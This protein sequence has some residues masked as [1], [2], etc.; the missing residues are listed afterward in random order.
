MSLPYIIYYYISPSG[1]N[2]VSQFLDSLNKKQ[3]SKV[4]RIFQYIKVYGLSAILPHTKKLS[5][6]PLWEIRILGEDNIRI[7]YVILIQ[8]TVLI[9]HGFIKKSQ[10]TPPKEIQI[11]LS[12]LKQWKKQRPFDK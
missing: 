6:T 2:P 4:L 8:N 7:F 5:G 10:K 3:Q 1:D 11:A 12:R 9:L